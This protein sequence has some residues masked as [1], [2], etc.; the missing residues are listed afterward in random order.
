MAKDKKLVRGKKMWMVEEKTK[1]G[2]KIR[3]A[4]QS[5]VGMAPTRLQ[6]KIA[7]EIRRS[8][9]SESEIKRNK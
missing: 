2:S 5:D 3:K 8:S 6:P 1:K 7:T 9:I 4:K